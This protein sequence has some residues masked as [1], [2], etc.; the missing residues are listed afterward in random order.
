MLGGYLN[1]GKIKIALSYSVNTGDLSLNLVKIFKQVSI[2]DE[3]R[4]DIGGASMGSYQMWETVINKKG[5]VCLAFY[6]FFVCARY[7]LN[8]STYMLH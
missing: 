7:K 5:K 4:V 2:E 6:S 3:E 8:C 1:D